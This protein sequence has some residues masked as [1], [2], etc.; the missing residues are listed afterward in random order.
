MSEVQMRIQLRDPPPSELVILRRDG[1]LQL[2]DDYLRE[3]TV[4]SGEAEFDEQAVIKCSSGPVFAQHYLFR[5]RIAILR[6]FFDRC[7]ADRCGILRGDLF[8]EAR[9]LISD[10][11]RLERWLQLLEA[12]AGELDSAQPNVIPFA[13]ARAHAAS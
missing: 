2:I 8:V 6:T 13:Q 3:D 11:E 9:E 5:S 10:A 1:A 12:I 7:D 4:T